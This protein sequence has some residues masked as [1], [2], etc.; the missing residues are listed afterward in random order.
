MYKDGPSPLAQIVLTLLVGEY[1]TTAQI[2]A[3]IKDE[4]DY[5]YSFIVSKPIEE[6]GQE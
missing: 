3:I 2:P 5:F 1:M 6:D 4:V